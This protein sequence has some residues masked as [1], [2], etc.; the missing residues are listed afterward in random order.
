MLEKGKLNDLVALEKQ[1]KPE[2]RVTDAEIRERVWLKLQSKLDERDR[3]A[4]ALAQ[5][6]LVTRDELAKIAAEGVIKD[7][8]REP[9]PAAK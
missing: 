5:A 1:S 9:G 8:P 6:W 2:E 7:W 3:E 4:D